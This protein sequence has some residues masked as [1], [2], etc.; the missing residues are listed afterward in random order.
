MARTA[1]ETI[2]P[3]NTSRVV[4]P[5]FRYSEQPEQTVPSVPPDSDTSSV[6]GTSSRH[7]QE[8]DNESTPETVP[9]VPPDSY[10]SS[11]ARTISRRPQELDNKSTAV[12][13]DSPEQ[14]VNSPVSQGPQKFTIMGVPVSPVR[15]PTVSITASPERI[16]GPER[17]TTSRVS[18]N[19]FWFVFLSLIPGS[20]T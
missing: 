10:A 20:V 9:S 12:S 16:E 7:S 17:V 19:F 4:E 3:S 6:A 14:T 8:F 18:S 11:V 1:T 2:S 15:L 13:S 5:D